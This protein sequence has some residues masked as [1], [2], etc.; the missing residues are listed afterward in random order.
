MARRKSGRQESVIPRA[1]LIIILFGA[2]IIGSWG[3]TLVA[4]S[5]S[6]SKI[7]SQSQL[8]VY[9]SIYWLK[10][11][12]ANDSRYLSVSD[13]RFTYTNLIIGRTGLYEYVRI[14]SDAI[15][16][17]RNESANYIIVTNIS[18]VQLPPVPA[19]FPW[20]NFPSSSNSNLTLVYQDPDV[21]IYEIANFT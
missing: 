3:Q 1:V 6:N 19:L 7:V 17:A 16:I 12:T 2:I 8:S 21:R 5:L 18:T 14:P 13:W 9:N 10:D 4:D 15:K 11:N 20:N